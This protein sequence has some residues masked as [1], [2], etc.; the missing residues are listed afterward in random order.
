MELFIKKSN[1]MELASSH[2]ER[3]R[4]MD[5]RVGCSCA[6]LV[7]CKPL[8]GYLASGGHAHMVFLVLAPPLHFVTSTNKART[9]MEMLSAVG[10]HCNLVL[11][12]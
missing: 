8:S 4:D 6:V 2:G 11:Q 5:S 10:F 12:W 9:E 3:E 1:L 7:N